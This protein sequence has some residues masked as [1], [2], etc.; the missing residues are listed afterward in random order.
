MRTYP[1]ASGVSG[2]PR[3]LQDNGASAA[4]AVCVTRCVRTWVVSRQ[5]EQRRSLPP[6]P[7]RR[8]RGGRPNSISAGRRASADLRLNVGR[9]RGAGLL[10][11]HG[12]DALIL[13]GARGVVSEEVVE[14]PWSAA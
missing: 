5:R 4:G 10:H 9:G 11:R 12:E 6:L 1:T 13:R 2:A 14:E 8:T 3:V 7:C